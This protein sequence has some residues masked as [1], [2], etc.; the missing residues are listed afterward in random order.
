MKEVRLRKIEV[1]FQNRF[2]T[3][4]QDIWWKV[5]NGKVFMRIWLM[6]YVGLRIGFIHIDVI[7]ISAS[8]VE[9]RDY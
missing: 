4:C 7:S 9:E 6:K 8:A 3:C 5:Y 2:L 1:K